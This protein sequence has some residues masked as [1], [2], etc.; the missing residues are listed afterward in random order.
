MLNGVASGDRPRERTGE[1]LVPLHR[2]DG[3]HRLIMSNE[4][5]DQLEPCPYFGR[6]SSLRREPR[7]R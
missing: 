5:M 1:I 7:L 2:N 3:P 4:V 6:P